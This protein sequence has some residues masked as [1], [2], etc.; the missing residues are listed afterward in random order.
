MQYNLGALPP[1][2][3]AF[4]RCHQHADPAVI[5]SKAF[6]IDDQLDEML[7]GLDAPLRTGEQLFTLRQNRARKHRRRRRQLLGD[8]AR[9]RV[10]IDETPAVNRLI[11]DDEVAAARRQTTRREWRCL[12]LLAH[13]ESYATIAARLGL[14]P[15][16]ARSIVCRS[17]A[18][19]RLL[20]PAA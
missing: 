5:D 13:D 19:L 15:G 4:A 18:R 2:W 1:N 20:I 14:T 8:Y 12:W 10:L 7:A 3:R 6:G 16:A 17:R 11:R 9:Q